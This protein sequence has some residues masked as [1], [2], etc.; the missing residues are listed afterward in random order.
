MRQLIQ[1]LQRRKVLRVGALYVVGAW[2]VLQVADLAF[3]GLGIPDAAIRY[4]WIGLLVGFPLALLF[5]WRYEITA[6]GILRTPARTD[7]DP[8]GRALRRSDHVVLASF[9]VIALLVILRVG[10]EIRTLPTLVTFGSPEWEIPGNT[11]A[12]M[13]L[14]NVTGDPDQEF[15][16]AGIHDQLITA[17]SRIGGLTVK[18][19]SSTRVYRNVI[20]PA[21]RTGLELRTAHLVEG[22]VLRSGNRLRVNVRLISAATE[23]NLWSESYEREI[24]DILTLENEVART[25]AEQVGVEL[26]ADEEVRLGPKR[27]V[28][29]Q[30]Y[31]TYLRGMYQLN[32]Y[33]PIGVEK[34]LDYLQQAVALDPED[35]L[36]YAGL[37]QGLTLIGH[38]ANPPPGVFARAR[39]AAEKA[40]ELDPLFPEAHAAMAEIQL[41]HDWDWDD[42]E[43]S[44]QR[45]LQL[46]PNLEFAHGHYAWLHQLLGRTDA[47]IEHMA[48]AQQIAPVTPIFTAW[49]GWLYWGADEPDRAIAEAQRALEV[50]PDFPFSLYVLGGAYAAKG[51][52]DD[53]LATY[54]RLAQ[55]DPRLGDWGLGF[56]YAQMGRHDE[57]HES[58]GR[59]AVNPGQKDLLMLGLIHGA[60]GERDEALRWLEAAHEAH[61]DWFPFIA[62]RNGYDHFVSMSLDSLRVDPRF[63][64]LIAPLG[65][66]AG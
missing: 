41:Y 43:T 14:E 65:V 58:T 17:L 20:Q 30:V 54:E 21:L 48:R 33:T 10:A 61:V 40:L 19:A 7:A 60:L 39:K 6:Q 55:I 15:F 35:P 31:E 2:V 59:L 26:T 47:S 50:N 28:N 51:R 1:E 3:P 9:L 56:T 32:Q 24:E 25:I 13:P 8:A 27:R 63:E 46:N 12:V 29:P 11:I 53:A 66:P 4:V 34:G 16:A 52:F 37:A 5:A 36:A 42:A 62:S 45:A 23:E 44:F 64:K 18:A 49:L 38:S 22:S 57:A